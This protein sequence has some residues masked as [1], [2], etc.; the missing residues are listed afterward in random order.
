MASQLRAVHQAEDDQTPAVARA[1]AR[2]IVLPFRVLR[3]DTETDFLAFSLPDAV[4][5]SLSGR[6]SLMVRS[7]ATAARFAP[8]TPDLQALAAEAD[9]DRVVIGTLLRAGDQLRVTIQ[10]VEAPSGTLLAAE[11]MQSSLGDLFP[12]KTTSPGA[13]SRHCRCRSSALPPLRP[14]RRKTV[15]P[16][17]CTFARTSKHGPMPGSPLRVTCTSSV[18]S[19]IPS[20]HPPG[21]NWVDVIGWWGN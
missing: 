2:L 1:I 19:W 16:M 12:Y 13:S 15:A 5:T 3:P 17:S 10:L 7:S 18:C 21:R 9:V 4:A 14:M 20:L 8:E 6:G 11:T